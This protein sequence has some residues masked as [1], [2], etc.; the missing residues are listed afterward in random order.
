MDSAILGLD[1]LMWTNVKLF[2]KDVLDLVPLPGYTDIYCFEDHNIRNVEL[3]GIVVAVEQNLTMM[4]YTVDDGTGTLTCIWWK[5]TIDTEETISLGSCVRILGL[6]CTFKDER[7]VKVF[8]LDVIS[9]PN[10]ELLHTLQVLALRRDHYNKPFD[11]SSKVQQNIDTLKQEMKTR[12]AIAPITTHSPY[13]NEKQVL[14]QSV[15][16]LIRQKFSATTP[17]TV[18]EL[19]FDDDIYELAQQHI[20]Q[21]EGQAPTRSQVL[22]LICDIFNAS[23]KEG[24][25]I[26]TTG[27]GGSYKLFDTHEL[28]QE[29]MDIIRNTINDQT[30]PNLGGVSHKYIYSMIQ[31]KYKRQTKAMINNCIHSMV[32]RSLIYKTD[33]GT[34][35]GTGSYMILDD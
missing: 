24:Y 35:K 29:I 16:E 20:E 7:K 21:S 26:N 33:Q 28:E 25:I 9:D 11:I 1:P 10:W 3:C 8:D 18:K 27:N 17:L 23:K 13:L 31:Y 30:T 15:L 32:E 2:I 34:D 5:D 12:K 22:S 6:V 4:I 14:Q 19:Q